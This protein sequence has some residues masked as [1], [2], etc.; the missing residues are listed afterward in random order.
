[1]CLN[2]RD[3]SKVL[4]VLVNVWMHGKLL[5]L[6]YAPLTY[7][8]IELVGFSLYNWEANGFIICISPYTDWL[9]SQRPLTLLEMEIFWRLFTFSDQIHFIYLYFIYLY[10]ASSYFFSK[11]SLTFTCF[12]LKKDHFFKKIHWPLL[13]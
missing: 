10:L 11:F 2:K 7:L 6:L 4:V 9:F 5:G 12:L 8:Q 3:K 1:M 13:D